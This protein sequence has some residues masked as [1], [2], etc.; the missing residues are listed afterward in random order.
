MIFGNRKKINRIGT[1]VKEVITYLILK[2]Y[3]IEATLQFPISNS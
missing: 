3:R 1:K 2:R